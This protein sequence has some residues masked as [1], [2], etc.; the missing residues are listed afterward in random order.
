[1]KMTPAQ[2]LLQIH[3]RELGIQT[4]PEYRFCS[5]QWRFDLVAL[6]RRWAFECN[7]H[8]Q[9]RHGTG[10]SEGFEKLNLA[11]P[12]AGEFLFFI[13]V[14][15]K[16]GKRK[17]GLRHDLLYPSKFARVSRNSHA[18]TKACCKSWGLSALVLLIFC[19]SMVAHVLWQVG[20]SIQPTVRDLH[21]TVLEAGLTLKNLKEASQSWKE[22]SEKQTSETTQ[23]MS[24][25]SGAARNLSG[26]ISR[27]DE[28]LNSRVLPSLTDMLT[29]QNSALLESQKRLQENLQSIAETTQQAQMVLVDADK[30]IADPNIKLAMDNLAT[31]SQNAAS[32]TAEASAT[33]A[34]I[35]K[36]VDYEVHEIT[37]PVSA[38]KKAML[39]IT[40]L[41]GRWFGY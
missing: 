41:A 13:T 35:H 37:K 36:G 2:I 10:W 20:P 19:L 25:L 29:Q 30:V 16:Q 21:T 4:M 12:K 18:M 8:W 3:L 11:K 6:D 23:A 32:A 24:N 7:G 15:S 40:Q 26:F 17:S 33:M 14:K 28:S 5:R 1:M 39:F 9:G 22:A 31:A 27:T 38:V 34:S